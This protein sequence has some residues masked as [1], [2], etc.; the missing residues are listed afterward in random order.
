MQDKA[1]T[2]RTTPAVY[3]GIDVCKDHLDVCLRPRGER[4]RVANDR[5]GHRLLA[6]RLSSHTVALV[7]MEPTAKYHRG[8]H[9]HLVARGFAVALVNPL[10]ARLFAEA[11]GRLAKTDAIDAATLALLAE[12]LTPGPTLPP[13]HA[14]ELLA[15][16]AGARAA[17]VAERVALDNRR[18]AAASPFLRR[19][20]AARLRG[21]D[22]HIATLD[23]QIAA[24]IA[25][26]PATARRAH[27]LRSIPGIGPVAATTLLAQL[28][29]IGQ[30]TA[31]QAAALAGLAPTAR[32]SGQAHRQRHI[33]GGRSQLRRA[34]YMAALT[35]SRRNPDLS[36]F[37][38]RL[39]DQGK[40]AKLALTAVARKLVILAN[41]LVAENRTWQPQTA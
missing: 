6:R 19:A 26:D 33:R 15:E 29:E 2:D 30:L 22:R 37:Y 14:Q 35:A 41:R 38:Q 25:A 18:Q 36:R 23:K 27:I 17:A 21:L 13:D 24:A 7:A 1:A 9:R 28:A 16:L 12:R 11:C 39:R 10:R 8:A 31:K 40:A 20:L 5:S 34:L 32:D 4:F 3:V